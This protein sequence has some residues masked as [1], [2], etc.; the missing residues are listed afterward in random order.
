MFLN[1]GYKKFGYE[2]MYWFKRFYRCGRGC[3]CFETFLVFLLSIE[4]FRF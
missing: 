3:L 4:I 2:F 1:M